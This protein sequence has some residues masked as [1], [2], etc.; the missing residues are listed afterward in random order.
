M[1]KVVPG[2]AQSP[3]PGAFWESEEELTWKSGGVADE[4]QNCS[5]EPG[6]LL[7]YRLCK[8][9]GKRKGTHKVILPALQLPEYQDEQQA[10][11]LGAPCIIN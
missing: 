11:H 1:G 4:F 5:E 10:E 8:A 6:S 9:Q 3:G 7:R 2:T